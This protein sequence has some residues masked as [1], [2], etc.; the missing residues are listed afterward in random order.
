MDEIIKSQ[1]KMLQLTKPLTNSAKSAQNMVQ[2]FTEPFSGN[3]KSVQSMGS[4]VSQITANFESV[5]SLVDTWPC[6]KLF[7][8]LESQIKT[9]IDTSIN[10]D[11]FL[12][13]LK[14]MGETLYKDYELSKMSKSEI[15]KLK[16]LS[17]ESVNAIGTVSKK[18]K[19]HNDYVEFPECLLAKDTPSAEKSNSMDN[20]STSQNLKVKKVS[21]SEAVNT[22]GQILSIFCSIICIINTVFIPSKTNA[23]LEENNALLKKQITIEQDKNN[24]LE[25]QIYL[26]KIENELQEEQLKYMYFIYSFLKNKL[27]DTETTNDNIQN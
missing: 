23:L 22:I 10:Y 25:T 11:S 12:K 5:Q 6:A 8:P 27:E 20:N 19:V 1:Q 9:A 14:G 17:I 7:L 4:H 24:K 2:N 15:V 13:S 16:D 26:Q 18:I 3:I 21:F